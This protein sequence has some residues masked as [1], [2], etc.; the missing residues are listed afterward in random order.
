MSFDKALKVFSADGRIY[1][2]EYAF[3][4]VNQFGMTGI[5]IRGT[6]SVAVCTQKKVPDKLINPDSVT[7]IF[8]ISN[9][10]GCVVVGNM[11]DARTVIQQMR[12]RQA[13]YKFKYGYEMPIAVMAS[14]IGDF[15]QNL[16]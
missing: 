5:A 15:L 9:T 3:K 10:A 11:N 13:E 6:D 12:H 7:N 2:M 8:N 1:Q 4:A 14:R 16:S